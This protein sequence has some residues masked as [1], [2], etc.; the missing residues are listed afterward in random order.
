MTR[1]ERDI[2]PAAT[3]GS[4]EHPGGPAWEPAQAGGE[5]GGPPEWS[6]L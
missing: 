6:G 5:A 2:A 1:I 4:G 3:E